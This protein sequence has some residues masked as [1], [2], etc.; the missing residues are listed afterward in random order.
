MGT[1]RALILATLAAGGAT[2][3]NAADLLPPP[4]PLPPIPVADNCNGCYNGWYIRADVGV[5]AVQGDQVRSSITPGVDPNTGSLVVPNGPI[6]PA[7]AALGDTA[8]AG[9]GV[10]YQFNNWLRADVTGEYRT[11]AS[12]RRGIAIA[13]TNGA[14]FPQTGFDNY[15]A[16]LGT[17]LFLANGYIDLGC[18]RGITPYVGAGVGVAAHNFHGLNDSG[19]AVAS[20]VS[21]GNFA[22]A[23]M[24]GVA[25]NVTPNLKLDVGYRYV[26][27]GSIQSNPLI[28]LNQPCFNERQSFRV[29]SHD[30]RVG[31]RYVFGEP[32]RPLP[33]PALVTKY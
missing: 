24:G 6:V 9:A 16:G 23:V 32:A 26:D 28:C 10:G 11:E 21:P 22:W 19:G 3:A 4:P 5:G 20:D 12:Y 1:F 15:S 17:A 27:M 31:L 30:V 25:F 14:G 18:W 8:M 7:Y 29:A 2:A 13:F 33:P